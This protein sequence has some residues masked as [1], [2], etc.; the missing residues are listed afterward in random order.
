MSEA[1][2]ERAVQK[3]REKRAFAKAYEKAFTEEMLSGNHK[4]TGSMTQ[5]IRTII[6]SNPDP[7]KKM[8][9]LR[10]RLK[11]TTLGER[12]EVRAIL[13]TDLGVSE[14]MQESAMKRQKKLVSMTAAQAAS[15]GEQQQLK[16]VYRPVETPQEKE[17]RETH[18]TGTYKEVDV[19]PGAAVENPF[20][21]ELKKKKKGGKKSHKKSH[22]KSG[23]K[24]HKKG[25]K[26]SHKR[27]H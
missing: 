4:I 8:E 24:S 2:D 15:I 25:G 3:A 26:K 13:E 19:Q 20:F 23:K 21:F 1:Q 12:V 5:D 17:Y 6:D 11:G 16:H 18:P 10:R 22:K 14:S 7:V 9:N 27:R